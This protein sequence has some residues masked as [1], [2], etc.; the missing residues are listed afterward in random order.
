MTDTRSLHLAVNALLRRPKRRIDVGTAHYT[1]RAPCLLAQLADA[2][3][4]SSSGTGG[5]TT[6]GSKAPLAM[7]ALDLWTE[8]EY[9]VAAWATDLNIDR[10]KYRQS[11]IPV[12]AIRASAR[13]REHHPDEA[14]PPVGLLLR[15]VAA[16]AVE[17][18][19]LAE[20]V[21]RNARRWAGR[22]AKMLTPDPEASRNLPGIACPHC[23]ELWVVEVPVDRDEHGQVV[24]SWQPSTADPAQTRT[25]AL[26]L[27]RGDTGVIRCLW[28]RACGLYVWR[29]DLA[30]MAGPENAEQP[31]PNGEAA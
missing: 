8:I 17:R 3:A 20:A 22:I 9:S 31:Q 24:Y 21:E 29:D 15:A 18:P 19:L 26:F 27:E 6:P 11:E 2:V 12:A 1:V 16:R 14:V 28:C 25:P 7:D 4:A 23:G 30:A 10:A 5:R 13:A